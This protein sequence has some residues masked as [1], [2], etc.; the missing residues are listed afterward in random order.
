MPGRPSEERP[1]WYERAFKSR[2]ARA[3]AEHDRER[4]ALG[5]AVGDQRDVEV[6]GVG[7][8]GFNGGSGD[9]RAFD[10]EPGAGRDGAAFDAGARGVE[11]CRARSSRQQI[12][13]ADEE[14]D[15]GYR[16]EHDPILEARESGRL[17]RP[18]A[19][20]LGIRER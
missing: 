7:L 9:G 6:V 17:R 5:P 13:D 11:E 20:L 4:L 18:G 1:P 8:L 3:E 10:V 15:A 19:L 2:G 16:R 14:G 12:A